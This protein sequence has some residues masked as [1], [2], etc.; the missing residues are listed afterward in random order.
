MRQ[1][2]KKTLTFEYEFS[3]KL[4]NHEVIGIIYTMIWALKILFRLKLES[5]I[6]KIPADM[7][8]LKTFENCTPTLNLKW[9]CDFAICRAGY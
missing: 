4:Y 8:M 6:G 1:S 9:L 5:S 2:D 7:D 3:F